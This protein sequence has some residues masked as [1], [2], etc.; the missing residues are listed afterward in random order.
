MSKMRSL[1][2]WLLEILCQAAGTTIWVAILALVKY[3]PDHSHYRYGYA[4]LLV[5]ISSMV[6]IEF[7]LTGYLVTTLLS[8]QF[9]PHRARYLYPSVCSALY[10][11]HSEIFF[12]GV[13]NRFIDKENLA[14]QVG[15][16][17][18]TFA[19]AFIGDRFRFPN[20]GPGQTQPLPCL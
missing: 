16:A 1:A 9:L 7:A 4:G 11:I 19:V 12:A 6:L 20:T 2:V 5:G 18:M 14:I 13:G 17:C 8:A 3:G 15:G 10:L